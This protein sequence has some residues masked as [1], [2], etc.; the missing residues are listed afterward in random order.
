MLG[1]EKAKKEGRNE[2]RVAGA[3]RG[4][5]VVGGRGVGGIDMAFEGQE[6]CREF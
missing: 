1:E 6:G 5:L 2:E 3:T 4:F